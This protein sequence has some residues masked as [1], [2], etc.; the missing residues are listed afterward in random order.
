VGNGRSRSSIVVDFGS[1]RKRV[2]NFVLVINSNLGP[3]LLLFRDITGFCAKI[4]T[5]PTSPLFRAKF[6]GVPLGLDR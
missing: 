2:C 5:L 6:G 4:A 1:N 3:I